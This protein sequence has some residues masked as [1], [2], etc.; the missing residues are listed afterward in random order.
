MIFARVQR[1]KNQFSRD[2]SITICVQFWRT[3][4]E[5][6][7]YSNRYRETITHSYRKYFIVTNCHFASLSVL[8]YSD[9]LASDSAATCF[10]VFAGR[11]GNALVTPRG[12]AHFCNRAEH[13]ICISIRKLRLFLSWIVYIHFTFVYVMNIIY[14]VCIEC[15]LYLSHFY[16]VIVK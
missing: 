15:N 8:P 2:I 10:P 16:R 5:K 6:V 11:P 3:F 4:S 12:A 13:Y 9:R 7:R 14:S 1:G